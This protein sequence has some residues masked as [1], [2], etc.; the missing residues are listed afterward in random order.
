MAPQN[1]V[2]NLLKSVKDRR[3]Q[4]RRTLN[5]GGLNTRTT[6]RM[7]KGIK[8]PTTNPF[9]VGK[10]VVALDRRILT[11]KDVATAKTT[12]YFDK[13]EEHADETKA[14]RQM[15]TTLYL[16]THK[17][18]QELLTRMV[19]ATR[20]GKA[21]KLLSTDALRRKGYRI[22]NA[23]MTWIMNG[24]MRLVKE[25]GKSELKKL[26][27]KHRMLYFKLLWNQ[28][29]VEM[30]KGFLGPCKAPTPIEALYSKTTDFHSKWQRFFLLTF[31]WIVEDS[32]RLRVLPKKAGIPEREATYNEWRAYPER[33]L[34]VN[35]D[36]GG[37]GDIPVR[38]MGV[39]D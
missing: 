20:H 34:I 35:L 8:L 33:P 3:K 37:F 10:K 38:H 16:R 14:R 15:A 5:T 11:P 27:A 29:P 2:S 28:D 13:T 39:F 31:T 22:T 1:P 4:E 7:F 25:V 32:F 23:R 9:L 24:L 30:A 17:P 36:L 21:M 18:T 19:V 26:S 6:Q 12:N